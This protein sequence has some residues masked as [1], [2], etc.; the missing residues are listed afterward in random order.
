VRAAR[1]AHADPVAAVVESEGGITLFRGKVADVMR[2]A[3]EGWLRGTVKLDGL[4]ED[5][6]HT[7]A[8]DFQNEWSIARRE[9]EVRATVPDLVILMDSGSGEAIGTETVR[10]GQRMTVIALPPPPLLT[11]PKG[12][13]HLGPRAFGYD[14]DF[15]SAFA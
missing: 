11:T 15:K 10:F 14:I 5:A 9:G 1:T 12:L 3:T 2:R 4:D 6:G 7:M 8:I 13:A